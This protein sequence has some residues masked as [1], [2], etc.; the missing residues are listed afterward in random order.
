MAGIEIVNPLWL[1]LLPP[2]V[3]ALV[4]VMRK[5]FVKGYMD[6]SVK[7]KRKWILA[8]RIAIITLLVLSLANLRILESVETQTLP[9]IDVLADNS[10]SMKV[11]DTSFVAQLEEGLGREVP[12]SL[13]YVAEGTDSDVGDKVLANMQENGNLLLVTDGRITGGPDL[14]DVVLYA[15]SLNATISAIE[16]E[17]IVEDAG[18]S[19]TG[20]TKTVTGVDNA[21]LV[22]VGRIGNENYGIDIE[23]D[24][25]A[26]SGQKE[27]GSESY[28]VSRKFETEGFHTITASVTRG[29]D[30]YTE[31]DVFY[32]TIKVV[33]R[34]K[35]LFLSQRDDPLFDLM[36]QLYNVERASILPGDLS[37]YHAVVVNDMGAADIGNTDSLKNFIIDGN[38]LMVVG[39]QNSFDFADYKGSVFEGLLPVAVGTGQKKRGDSNIVILIDI[40]GSTSG[41]TLLGNVAVDVQKALAVDIINQLAATNRV[42][43][44]A[45][46]ENSYLIGEM[47]PIGETKLSLTD[48][49]A[50]LSSGGGTAIASGL[51]AALSLLTDSGG[52]NN[53]I[54]LTD[55]R[56]NGQLDMDK[57]RELARLFG[58]T[59]TKLFTVGVGKRI[60][61]KLLIEL[62]QLAGGVYFEADE[63]NKFK[64]FFGEP[65][66]GE[67]GAANS[68]IVIDS[69][70]FITDGLDINPVLDAY[71][72]VRP[73]DSAQLLV[74][75]DLGN[76]AVTV[77]RYG[78][79]RVAAINAF[80]AQGNLGTLLNRENS[81]LV[82]RAINWG[83]GDPERKAEYSVNVNDVKVDEQ[84]RIVVKSRSLPSTDLPLVKTDADTYTATLE[85]KPA[86][87]HEE[88]GATYAVNYEREYQHLG[89]DQAFRTVVEQT[90]GK[91]FNPGDVNNILEHVKTTSTRTRVAEVGLQWMLLASALALFLVE[92]SARRL[93]TDTPAAGV[94]G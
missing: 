59:G 3:A 1:A 13:K 84:P 20:P 80:A 15:S 63:T 26:E 47:K 56:S 36:A 6:E 44:I 14:G 39:G 78:L 38:G 28:V 25:A 66:P 50:R 54:M 70:H 21:F 76:P 33:E 18:V 94:E 32:K 75:N 31:N 77:W 90:G 22:E 57:A 41:K 23:I 73:K 71:N 72:Q 60:N 65:E 85:K 45:F 67:S 19:I 82:T 55:G 52:D 34:P 7:K 89:I 10:N 42:A 48:R 16:M 30:F 46:N 17:P 79:G 27:T 69:N 49:I 37:Q 40:S 43:V 83:I 61:D 86:G 74:T 88:L 8:S 93:M 87:F 51:G 68:L 2:L 64:V 9:R 4:Y 81:K 29:N 12:T 11:F 91:L 62:A 35:V 5:D 53:I 58:Q 24:G 92:V